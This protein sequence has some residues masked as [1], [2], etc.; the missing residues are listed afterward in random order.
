MFVIRHKSP[1]GG[2]FENGKFTHT[3]EADDE[4]LVEYYRGKGHTVERI[5]QEEKPADI[6]GEKPAKKK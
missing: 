3:V 6:P 1:K 2:F 5:E 4:K